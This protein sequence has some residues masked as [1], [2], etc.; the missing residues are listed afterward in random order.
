MPFCLSKRM[1]NLRGMNRT[2]YLIRSI[3]MIIITRRI[4]NKTRK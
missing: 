2:K 1:D 4:K 3:I